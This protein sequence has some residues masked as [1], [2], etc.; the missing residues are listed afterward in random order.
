MSVTDFPQLSVSFE[1]RLFRLSG[2]DFNG[3]LLPV[4]GNQV[5]MHQTET[6]LQIDGIKLGVEEDVPIPPLR[7]L[8]NKGK[9]SPTSSTED[10]KSENVNLVTIVT[11]S[12]NNTTPSREHTVESDVLAHL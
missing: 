12:D 11:V 5:D 4:A 9:I 2:K 1:K 8:L 6:D 3:F 7:M 10:S